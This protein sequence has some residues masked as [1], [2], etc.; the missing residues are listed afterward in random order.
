MVLSKREKYIAIGSAAAVAILV[1]DYF[2]VEPYL[3]QRDAIQTEIDATTASQ[4]DAADT[5]QKKHK[6]EKVWAEMQSGG[7]KSSESQAESQVLNAVLKWAD[8]SGVA[9]QA[10]KPE[11]STE[12]DKFQVISFTITGEGSMA[13]VS[14]LMWAMETASIPVRVN[15]MQINPKREGVDDLSVRL[16]FSTL[17]MPPDTGKPTDLSAASPSARI[18]AQYPEVWS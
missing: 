5:L 17:C 14:R 2:L 18:A 11:R 3:A 6:L 4:N 12:E 9:L 1:L 15:E 10:L 7:L 13:Q 8:E 16:N